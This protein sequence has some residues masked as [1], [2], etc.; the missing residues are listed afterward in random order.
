M[1]ECANSLC[2]ALFFLLALL[3]NSLSPELYFI[4]GMTIPTILQLLILFGFIYGYNMWSWVGFK[5][6]NMQS[7]FLMLP[8]VI[9]VYPCLLYLSELCSFMVPKSTLTI[10][11]SSIDSLHNL[12]PLGAFM[13]MA[14]IP[15][16]CEELICRG[17]IY[18]VFRSRSCVAA[19]VVSTLCF[20]LLHG[21]IEQAVYAGCF[22]LMLAIIREM[23]GSVYPG[24]FAHMIFN[25]VSVLP[26]FE[27]DN[28]IETESQTIVS[29]SINTFAD[30]WDSHIE[31]FIT[32]MVG[33]ALAT[34]IFI[35]LKKYNNF[36]FDSK[37]NYTYPVITGT[38]I[39]GWLICV[40]LGVIL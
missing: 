31:L 3:S 25:S 27:N 36:K 10:S 20:A 11:S 26:T 23:T 40:V 1:T 6:P 38:Y 9:F 18:G 34:V 2:F 32:S 5:I 33:L 15:A 24:I 21:N 19:I 13:L 22:G 39:V 30:F 14:V 37:V 8:F 29:D 12:G 17:F 35:I 28:V 16:V 7:I 4:L